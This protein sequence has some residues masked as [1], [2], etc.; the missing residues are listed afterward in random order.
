[1]KRCLL[2][3]AFLLAAVAVGQETQRRVG[4]I[5]F[6]GYAGLDLDK[7]RAA[8]PLREGDIYPGP[9]E[10]VGG[11]EEAFR[12]VIG[13]TPTD[14][15]PVCCDARGNYMIYVGLPGNSFR[16]VPYNPAPTGRLRLP[17]RIVNLYEQAME[18]SSAAVLKGVAGEDDSK[19]YALSTDPTLRRKQLATRRYAVRHGRLVRSVLKSSSDA[20][21]R[22]VAAYVLGYARQSK[23]QIAALV[24][25]SRDADDTVRNNAVRALS[26]LAGSS[27]DAARRI[28]AA[29]FIEML[30][31]GSWT[32][33]NKAGFLLVTLSEGRDPKLLGRLRAEAISSL[34]EMARW[35]IAGHAYSARILLGRIAS[36][37]EARLRQLVEA[38]QVE[39]IIDALHEAR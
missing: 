6:Y 16:R 24:R 23:E 32:D 20:R 12:R 18:A 33:R 5:E 3:I 27:P 22:I 21:Q 31:S 38:G 15:A 4:E 29:G 19:G 8:L 34:V 36:I 35:R 13:R 17:T 9:A 30:N 26:V 7:I 14:V 25:A 11:L 1:M 37:E 28:P 2:L 10:A 39:A